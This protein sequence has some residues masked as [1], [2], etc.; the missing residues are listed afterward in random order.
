MYSTAQL[1]GY[2]CTHPAYV[3]HMSCP[4]S[5]KRVWQL[6]K[7]CCSFI[8]RFCTCA[9]VSRARSA[10]RV[11]MHAN[12][13]LEL[14]CTV[15]VTVSV[16]ASIVYTCMHNEKKIFLKIICE[17]THAA[18]KYSRGLI[19]PAISKGSFKSTKPI[20]HLIVYSPGHEE[21]KNLCVVSVA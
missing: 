21:L 9:D 4:A 2:V 18:G 12:G 5:G 6:R 14:S 1:Q 3:Q 15:Y 10:R 17:I 8:T 19:G 13:T 16:K 11:Q 20:Y 7:S